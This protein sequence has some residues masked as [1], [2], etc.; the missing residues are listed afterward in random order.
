MMNRPRTQEEPY[1]SVKIVQKKEHWYKT[2]P[3]EKRKKTAVQ[4]LRKSQSMDLDDPSEDQYVEPK[5]VKLPSDT[6]IQDFPL[7]QS[8]ESRDI[9]VSDIYIK[10]PI[11]T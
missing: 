6:D 5:I 9:D 8:F 1:P 3:K 2:R 7:I 10:V 11:Q 4:L